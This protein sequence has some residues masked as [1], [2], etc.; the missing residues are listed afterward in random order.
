MKLAAAA[1]ELGISAST[2]R[3]WLAA[4]A[5]C[6]A[7]RAGRGNGAHVDVE[8]VLRWREARR[9][10][11]LDVGSLASELHA[12]TAKAVFTA[13]RQIESPRKR[14]LAAAFATAWFAAAGG[15][16]DALRELDDVP[17]L[18]A[19]PAEIRYLRNLSRSE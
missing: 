3:R 18:A 12:Q 14:E 19:L 6:V 10:G 7:G 9:A 4:G 15:I 1:R 11:T 13:W 16:T 8:A 2:L 5:P 17:E